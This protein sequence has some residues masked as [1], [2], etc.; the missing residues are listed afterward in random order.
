[1]WTLSTKASQGPLISSYFFEETVRLFSAASQHSG[2]ASSAPFPE[3]QQLR[4]KLIATA[5]SLRDCAPACAA[6]AMVLTSGDYPVFSRL[7]VEVEEFGGVFE[8]DNAATLMR[9]A[10]ALRSGIFHPFEEAGIALDVIVRM[11]PE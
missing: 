10:A 1:M 6:L 8:S 11:R 2:T 5:E 4:L 3:L 7:I 9:K